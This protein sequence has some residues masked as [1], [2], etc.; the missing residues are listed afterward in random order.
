[1][2]ERDYHVPGVPAHVDDLCVDVGEKV[3]DMDR[4][5]APEAVSLSPFS[6]DPA[7][8][9]TQGRLLKGLPS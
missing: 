3:S 8:G 4:T 2:I 7:A 5:P 6:S 9:R 1:M